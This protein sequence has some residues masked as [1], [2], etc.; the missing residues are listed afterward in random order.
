MGEA[1]SH[2]VPVPNVHFFAA[3]VNF[4]PRPWLEFGLTRTAQWCG[5]D[6]PCDW[7]TFTDMVLGRDNQ[8]EDGDDAM[9]SP[10]TRWRAMTCACARP[11]A[12]CRWPS[13]HS[14]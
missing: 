9:N 6:R 14:G 8:V 1:E 12:R 3:R 5:G 11:G 13:T 2:D 4:K 7:D 10:A